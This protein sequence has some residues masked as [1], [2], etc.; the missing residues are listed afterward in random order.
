[1][2]VCMYSI[3]EQERERNSHATKDSLKEREDEGSSVGKRKGKERNI[4]T[5]RNC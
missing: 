2:H 3:R 4:G 5:G 1:M